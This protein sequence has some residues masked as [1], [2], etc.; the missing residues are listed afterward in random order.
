MIYE[1]WYNYRIPR[2][3]DDLKWDKPAKPAKLRH[4]VVME[5]A[6]VEL[7]HPAHSTI[8]HHSAK[9]VPAP[10]LDRVKYKSTENGQKSRNYG[11][12]I[13]G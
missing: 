10:K 3:F 9:F 2:C 13:L 11:F 4:A 12:S 8:T 7:M 5:N 1:A 6:V